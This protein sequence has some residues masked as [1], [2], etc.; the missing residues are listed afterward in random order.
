[1]IIVFIISKIKLNDKKFLLYQ[2]L[3][4]GRTKQKYIIH[5]YILFITICALFLNFLQAEIF[6]R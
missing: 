2:I 1:M 6:N 5:P 3:H 4:W